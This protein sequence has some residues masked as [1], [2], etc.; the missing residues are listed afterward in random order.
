MTKEEQDNCRNLTVSV[1]DLALAGKNV[2]RISEECSLQR[3]EQNLCSLLFEEITN[4]MQSNLSPEEKVRV[5]ISKGN[6]SISVS[7]KAHAESDFLKADLSPYLD[8]GE[9]IEQR[10]R[11]VV[12]A[13]NADK[14]HVRFKEKKQNITIVICIGKQPKR[15]YEDEI[16]AFYVSHIGNPP[17]PWALI[18]FLIKQRKWAFLLSLFIKIGRSLPMIVIPIISANLI[19]IVSQGAISAQLKS[20]LMNIGIGV[21]SLLI[22]A[23]FVY[24][25]AAYYRELCRA[26]GASL[27]NVMV[28]KL[29]LLSISFHNES[30]AGA[31]AN[32]ILNSVDAIEETFRLM[33]TQI[34]T[35]GVYIVAAIIITLINCP[36]MS[37]FYVLFIPLAVIMATIFRKPIRK[38]NIEF[39]KAMEETSSAVTE[40]LDMVE[41]TRAHGLQKD[42]VSRI[43][44]HTGDIHD[45]GK[46]LDITNEVF[47]SISWI[48][49]QFFQLL[50]LAF[51]AYLAS[52]NIISIGMIALFQAYFSATVTRLSSFINIIPQFTRGLDACVSIGE[53]LCVDND[54]HKGCAV[55]SAFNGRIRFSNVDFR[56]EANGPM[57]LKNF[58]VDIPARSSLALVGGSGSGKTTLMKLILGFILPTGGSVEIDGVSTADMNLSV[59]RKHLAVVPQ[60][61]MLFSGTL[62]QNLTYGA[63]LYVSRKRIMEV[64]KKVGLDDY[65]NSLS[66]GL[67]SPITESGSNLSGGQ[68]QRLSIARALLRD[69][70]IIILDEPTSALDQENEQ[71][72]VDI[73]KDINGSCT[74]IMV[75]HRL[76]TIKNFDSIAVLSEGKI[77][78]QDTFNNLLNSNELFRQMK[79]E[80]EHA[81][82]I[83]AEDETR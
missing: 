54:E 28:R 82:T 77:V 1:S 73:L 53:V 62:Y 4:C 17:T 51:S 29:Q 47:G 34:A 30:H 50:A 61:T 79:E 57:I 44:Q 31:I 49:L 5:K 69:P 27:R 38:K 76:N 65:V 42:E 14:I 63:P 83:K 24:F 45:S 66:H 26:M 39:R 36:I 41:I 74:I 7:L 78:Q 3:N 72:I 75:A 20:F 33:A 40:M 56:Y 2:E 22:H 23:L 70:S 18:R 16:E 81:N 60:H 46:R 21:A 32:K 43:S 35:I 80:Q 12:L 10:I 48:T 9:E 11:N 55:P 13:S 6:H 52:Q 25:D 71:R 67:D 15:N 64:L 59:F 8:E 19:D 58:N 68:M 37:L